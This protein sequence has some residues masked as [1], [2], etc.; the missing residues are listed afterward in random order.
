MLRGSSKLWQYREKV[1]RSKLLSVLLWKAERRGWES[2]CCGV[3]RY[4]WN[5]LRVSW[6]QKRVR[7]YRSW[8]AQQPLREEANCEDVEKDSTKYLEQMADLVCAVMQ[9]SGQRSFK[10]LSLHNQRY[11]LYTVMKRQS[12]RFKMILNDPLEYSN[13]R[14]V[15]P[16]CLSQRLCWKRWNIWR[17]PLVWATNKFLLYILLNMCWHCSFWFITWEPEHQWLVSPPSSCYSWKM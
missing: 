1:S 11:W 17:F 8:D 15:L 14:V 3:K 12:P 4:A 7:H 16:A 2:M 9:T 6:W 10:A 13:R 5:H